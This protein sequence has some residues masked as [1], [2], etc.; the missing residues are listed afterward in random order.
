MAD[1]VMADA[2]REPALLDRERADRRLVRGDEIARGDEEDVAV[3]RERD[4]S[5]R[6]LSWLSTIAASMTPRSKS[7]S[8]SREVDTRIS[9][10]T[11]GS[12]PL[13]RFNSSGSSLPTM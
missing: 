1:H 13:I 3:G 4:P 10:T 5:R 2:D 12:A 8:T 9:S 11:E 7:S 6:R